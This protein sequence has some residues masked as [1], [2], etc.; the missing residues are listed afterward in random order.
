MKQ[1]RVLADAEAFVPLDHA[2]AAAG[3]AA[4]M[5]CPA[6]MIARRS[7]AM[8]SCNADEPIPT[9]GALADES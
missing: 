1:P 5:A 6:I 4:R 9:A 8:M 7:L 2:L 3:G